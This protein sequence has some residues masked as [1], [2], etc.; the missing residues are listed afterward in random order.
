MLISALASVVFTWPLWPAAGRLVPRRG[1]DPIFHVW[2]LQAWHRRFDALQF[3][4]LFD[5]NNFFPH[6]DPLVFSDTFLGQALLSWPAHLLGAGPVAAHNVSYLLVFALVPLG[7]YLA[8][9]WLTASIP[10]ALVA[11]LGVGWAQTRW[12]FL[13]H[14]NIQSGLLLAPAL[15]ALVLFLRS[16]S[17]RWAAVA[18]ACLGLQWWFSGQLA[19]LFAVVAAPP[20]VLW[21]V[22]G[23][24]RAASA[25][26]RRAR[27]RDAGLAGGL[28]AV[29]AAPIAWGHLQVSAA[30]GLERTVEDNVA[31]S[32]HWRE[33]LGSTQTTW[34]AR[35]LAWPSGQPHYLGGV[36]LAL[37]AVALLLACRPRGVRRF[38]L[39]A[40]VPVVVLAFI[41]VA[42]AVLAQGPV[43]RDGSTLPHYHLLQAFPPLSALRAPAR[44]YVPLSVALGL[45]A[46]LPVALLARR[47]PAGTLLALAVPLLVAWDLF[48]PPFHLGSLPPRSAAMDALGQRDPGAPV[49][50]LPDGRPDNNG[51]VSRATYHAL[52]TTA[53]MSGTT[54]PLTGILRC[55]ANRFP[56]PGALE[57]FSALGLRYAAV[58]DG[59]RAFSAEM[60][61]PSA[62]VRVLATD[63]PTTIFAL[64]PPVPARY[65]GALLD[66][67][68]LPVLLPSR[69]APGQ[70]VNAAL[71]L[72]ALSGTLRV[73]THPATRVTVELWRGT[74]RLDAQRAL[75]RLPAVLD[76]RTTEAPFTFTA[77]PEPGPL[78]VRVLREGAPVAA[79]HTEVTALPPAEG[80]VNLEVD[81]TVAPWLH[82]RCAPLRVT[83]HNGS[84]GVLR[85][86]PVRLALPPET[87]KTVLDVDFL[88]GGRAFKSLRAYQWWRYPALLWH[89]LGPGDSATVT[90]FLEAPAEL[91]PFTLHARLGV[92]G[93]RQALAQARTDL[94]VVPLAR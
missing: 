29:L 31:Y 53:G 77:P 69:C 24:L 45:L 4:P 88:R 75:V 10:A 28:A 41:A 25:D 42:S 73:T 9:L 14:H 84:G 56:E 26:E 91:G 65:D 7:A 70:P 3:F 13:D 62:P 92:V 49:V 6:D 15:A 43:A 86:Y 48:P 27:L 80:P 46:S 23:L 93:R 87:G 20:L 57:L 81:A 2:A 51:A 39:D 74:D 55:L 35:H 34:P 82:G 58:H 16:P 85:A 30:L 66:G 54:P 32:V 17:S 68:S 67:R 8:S 5:A 1:E 40:I 21:A 52:R 38:P 37:A 72:S 50:D 71:D 61:Q 63:G 90:A 19:L 22:T 18:G 33:F 59:W 83:V 44:F 78:E 89:D 64:P 76:A 79:G 47:G 60:H 12:T 94:D 11:L 36:V